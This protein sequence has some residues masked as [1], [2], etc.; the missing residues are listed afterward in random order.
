MMA[1]NLQWYMRLST[2]R[3]VEPRC[4]YATVEACP[5]Y[6]QSLSLLGA[7]GCT[8]MDPAEDDRLLEKWKKSDLWPRTDEQAT[9]VLGPE[10]QTKHFLNFCPEV[11]FGQ[12][13][14]FASTLQRY[15]SEVDSDVAHERLQVRG[16]GANDWRWSWSNVESMHYTACPLYS[17]LKSMSSTQAAPDSLKTSRYFEKY[18]RSVAIGV[19]VTVVG[20]LVLTLVLSVLSQLFL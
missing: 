6:Y 9:S 7:A 16:A 2:E 15:P 19:T 20:G 12:F 5:R 14:L 11:S 17:P 4:P 10:G 8:S 1:P 18:F 3:S 13:H